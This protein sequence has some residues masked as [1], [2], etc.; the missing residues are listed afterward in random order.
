MVEQERP[1]TNPEGGTGGRIQLFDADVL[2]L[3]GTWSNCAV[4]LGHTWERCAANQNSESSPFDVKD[5]DGLR[6]KA[7]PGHNNTDVSRAAHEKIA[8][9]LAALL[10]LPIPPVTLFKLEGV[11]PQD[12]RTKLPGTPFVC[13]SAWAFPSCDE[14]AKHVAVITE[15]EK[16]STIAALSA[17]WVFDSWISADDRLFSKHILVSPT[18]KPPLKIACID[19][20]FSLSRSW[21]SNPR[22]NIA[23]NWEMPFEIAKRDPAAVLGIAKAIV[24]ITDAKVGEIVNRIGVEWLP[25]ARRD[26]ILKNLLERKGKIAEIVGV[27]IV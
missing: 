1:P 24:G 19:Y 4:A 3:R 22:T 17:V 23:A 10:D 8:S 15:E 21:A 25:P 16:A 13:V 7:N 5:K 18:G 6:G 11:L 20:A 14:W 2:K 9:D 27:T 26:L 12:P